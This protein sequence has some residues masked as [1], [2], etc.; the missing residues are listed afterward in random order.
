LIPRVLVRLL[1]GNVRSLRLVSLSPRTDPLDK[2]EK[3]EEAD[4]DNATVVNW[5]EYLKGHA[6][7]TT[8]LTQQRPR[9]E[10]HNSDVFA[11]N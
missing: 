6:I 11:P 7:D 5:Q 8:H 10:I 3:A 2:V 9:G 4:N 1:L